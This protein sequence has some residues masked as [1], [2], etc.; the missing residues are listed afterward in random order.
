MKRL[1]AADE[2]LGRVF[3][4]LRLQKN[5]RAILKHP[6]AKWRRS[7]MFELFDGFRTLKLI[8][9]LRDGGLSSLPWREALVA[10][11]FIEVGTEEPLE[12]LHRLRERCFGL[13]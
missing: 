11:P 6:D 2:A 3:D 8:H 5:I 4:G 12:L 7:S 9:A 13:P 10:A 1:F